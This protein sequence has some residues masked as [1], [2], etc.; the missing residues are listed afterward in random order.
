MKK[1]TKVLLIL[2]VLL[3]VFVYII[4]MKSVR[5][6][7]SLYNNELGYTVTLGMKKTKV[8]KMLGEPTKTGDGYSY[9]SLIVDYEDG[10]V[11]S[12]FAMEKHWYTKNMI[13]VDMYVDDFTAADGTPAYTDEFNRD[14]GYFY[15]S[16]NGRRYYVGYFIRN[17]ENQITFIKIAY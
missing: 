7:D 11:V 4:A 13:C 16:A 3:A 17:T 10:A 1:T 5:G 2:S 12:M 14:Y 9:D 8:D 6:H 15:S